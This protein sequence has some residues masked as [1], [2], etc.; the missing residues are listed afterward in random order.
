MKPISMHGMISKVSL[1]KKST[2]SVIVYHKYK[3]NNTNVTQ[4]SY[5]DPGVLLIWIMI[6]QGP[7][8]LTVGAGWFV[9][10]FVIPFYSPCL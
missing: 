3:N 7:T 10:T 8:V 1:V 9:W 2:V 4:N 6:E 5:R